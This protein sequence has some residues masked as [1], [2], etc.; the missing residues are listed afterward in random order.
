MRVSHCPLGNRTYIEAETLY[1]M[2]LSVGR[3]RELEDYGIK[4]K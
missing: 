2:V 3:M 4:Q 1:G